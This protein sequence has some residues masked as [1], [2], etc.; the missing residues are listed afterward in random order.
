MSTIRPVSSAMVMKLA[1]YRPALARRLPAHQRFDAGDAAARHGETRLEM[2][3]QLVAL[4]GL[5]QALFDLHALAELAA[6]L[7]AEEPAAMPCCWSLARYMAASAFFSSDSGSRPWSGIQ[8]HADAGVHRISLAVGSANSRW[9]PAG[10]R[11]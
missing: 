6:Q 11:G 2:Q 1:G 3:Q 7:G 4:D 5:A 10:S 9:W 8:G